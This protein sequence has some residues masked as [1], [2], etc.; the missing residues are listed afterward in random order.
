LRADRCVGRADRDDQTPRSDGLGW[1][2][3]KATAWAARGW[4]PWAS[5]LA[6]SR[7]IVVIACMTGSFESRGLNSTHIHGTRVPVEEPSTASKSEV[8][9]PA[10][11]RPESI[12]DPIA[13]IPASTN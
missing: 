10:T 13:V 1:A 9:C 5:D 6:M 3:A 2:A 12:V 7:P 4:H 11:E 8:R